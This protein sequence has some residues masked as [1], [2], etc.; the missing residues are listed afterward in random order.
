MMDRCPSEIEVWKPIPGYEGLYEASNQ[1][2]I[3]TAYGK[4]T[5]SA[6][7]PKRVWTQRILKLK[8]KERKGHTGKCDARV[9]LWKDGVERTHLVSRLVAMSFIPCPFDKLSVNHIDGDPSNNNVE[10]LEW[11]TIAENNRHAFETGLMPTQKAV[12]L[13]DGVA[14]KTLKFPSMSSADKFL[15]RANGYTSGALAYGRYCTSKDGKRY[16][17]ML[18]VGGVAPS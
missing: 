9:C 2:R 14:Q 6:R 12:V 1:G 17:P 13:I 16:F 8:W 4:T 11:V 10:N 5:A 15:R 3:R 7:F 18:D